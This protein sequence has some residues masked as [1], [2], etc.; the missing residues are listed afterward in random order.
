MSVYVSQRSVS[1]QEFL[2][3]ATALVKYTI[4]KTKKFPKSMQ[5]TF[6][7]RL[8]NLSLDVH[9][10][11][12]RA[13]SVY[14]NNRMPEEDFRFREMC[15]IKARSAI[16]SMSSLLTILFSMCMEG[17]NFL[18]DKKQTVSTFK[19]WARLLNY[20]AALLKGLIESDKKRYKRCKAKDKSSLPRNE[21]IRAEE[22]A[23]EEPLSAAILALQ[24]DEAEQKS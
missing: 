7:N 6:T 19:E 15:L 21:L 20:E 2:K 17:N 12:S 1:G 10:N 13:N 14:I 4:Q 11:V 9:E 8:V 22:E 24:D 5:F 18:G 16:F 3:N 23:S